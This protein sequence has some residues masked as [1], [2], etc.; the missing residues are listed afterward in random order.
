[1]RLRFEST[2]LFAGR[3]V[4]KAYR[5]ESSPVYGTVT[6]DHD[7]LMAALDV[8]KH[9]HC[10]VAEPILDHNPLKRPVPG[11]T[12]AVPTSFDQNPRVCAF[13]DPG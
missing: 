10:D 7:A 5:N 4:P 1:M 11:R 8:D 12:I 9:L 3:H 2:A 13:I 6:Q